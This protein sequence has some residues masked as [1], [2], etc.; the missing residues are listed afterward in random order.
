MKSGTFYA[1]RVKR[2]FSRLR[3]EYGTVQLPDPSDPIDALVLGL[4]SRETPQ[5]N[6][7][8][9][10][11]SLFQVMVDYNEMR[12]ST[13]AEIRQQIQ[14]HVPN[15]SKRADA[16]RRALNAVYRKQHRI[17]L[18]SL[19]K[20]GRREARQYL[21]KLDGVD[22]HAAAYV[23]LWSLGGHAVPV[24]LPMFERMRQD[25][26]IE[27]SATIDEVQAFLERNIAASD[28]REF[29]LLMERY[30]EGAAA[31][32]SGSDGAKKGATGKSSRAR[33]GSEPGETRSSGKKPVKPTGGS[34]NC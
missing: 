1:K 32:E 19:R 14:S 7:S 8:R 10:V 22:A 24:D 23:I 3:Q 21:E 34:A 18:E 31:T 2:L 29:C 6:A 5:S 26:L 30:V 15:A 16:I 12:V 9:A 17:C 28:A 27:P 33:R 20:L 4:L 25:E 11:E 13:I